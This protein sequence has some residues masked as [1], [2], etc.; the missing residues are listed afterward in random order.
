MPRFIAFRRDFFLQFNRPVPGFGRAFAWP[1]GIGM[2]GLLMLTGLALPHGQPTGLER[3]I[4]AALFAPAADALGLADYRV[5]IEAL[6]VEGV[7]R[8]LSSL[9]FDPHRRTLFGV[10]NS[11]PHVVELTTDGR[12]LRK[13]PLDGLKDP[14][15]IEYVAPGRYVVA[16]ERTQRL[17]E[18][19]IDAETQR[20]NAAAAPR[21]TIA[22][23]GGTGNK[24]F[25]GLAHDPG[26]RRL[27]VG[28]ERDPLRIYEVTGFAGQADGP[29]D[30]R[31]ADRPARDRALFIRDLSGLHF[32]AASGHLLV[33]SHESR[34][35]LELD[36]DGRPVGKLSLRGGEHGLARDVPQAEGLAIGDDG[37]LYV[38]SEPNL[39]YAFKRGDAAAH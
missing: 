34:L 4:R 9:T 7:A 29:P 26:T 14:E 20:I 39:F 16:D 18:I 28:K 17:V 36:D 31:V 32:D 22:I 1:A 23:G 8:D 10:T 15:A 5:V 12:L 33:L 3:G 25:E 38:V 2:L 24:G 27:F 35:V 11:D 13:I 37:T 6:P 19:G 21:L 30:I